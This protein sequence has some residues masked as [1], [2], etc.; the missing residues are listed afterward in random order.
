MKTNAEKTKIAETAS[1]YLKIVE[2]SDEDGCFVSRCLGLFLGGCHG[3]DEVAVYKKLNALVHSHVASLLARKKNL[4]PATS[5]KSYS[6]KFVVRIAPDLHK[7][8]ALRAQARGE[9]LNQYVAGRLA[10]A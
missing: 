10:L 2:W 5:G 1:R 4:P 3:D 8:I 7:G 6:G 9:S